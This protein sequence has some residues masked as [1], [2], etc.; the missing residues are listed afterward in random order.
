MTKVAPAATP[1][2]EAQ[3]RRNRPAVV[4]AA[5][6]LLV[7]VYG[8]LSLLNNPRGTLGTDTG[9]KLATL[10]TMD[11]NDTFD[12]DLGYWAEAYDPDGALHPLY[13]TSHVGERWV[14]VTT[15]P[16]VLAARP[17][18]SLGGERAVLALPMLGAAFA[19]LAA[20]ALARR[21][22][23]GDGWFAFWAVGLAT[24]IAIYALDFWEHAPGVAF[25]VWGIVFAVDLVDRRAGWGG[26]LASGALFGAAATMRTEALV[27]AAVTALVVAA[28]LVH[29]AFMT[30]DAPWRRFVG[31][32]T[33]GI[34]GLGGVLV[35][36]QLLERAVVGGSIRAGRAAGTASMGGEG[37]WLRMREAF[38]TA[39]GLNRFEPTTD[40]ILGG[41]IVTVVAFAAWR[42]TSFDGSHRRIGL[43]ALVAAVW[44][45]GMQMAGGLG[46]V[47]G[48]LSASPLAA[49]GIAI[50]WSARR[51]RTPGAIALAAVPLV[52]FFQFTGGANPQWG[53]RYVLVTGT[54]LAVGA[55]VVL[56]VTPGIA[57]IALFAVALMVTVAGLAW[58]SQRSNTV[59]DAIDELSTSDG[60][61][62]VSREGHVL[63][64]VGAAYSSNERWLTAED[65]TEFAAAAR[66]ARDIDAPVM[67]VVTVPDRPNPT[68]IEGWKRT[69]STRF[70][71]LPGFELVT[72]T[73]EPRAA[74]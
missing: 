16:M 51:W 32:G 73:Y 58:L 4:L 41:L 54:V 7:A 12:P 63:R 13:Y 42:L 9:G 11:R 69:D 70:E 49:A 18:Y 29:G 1:V 6:L 3:D 46:F 53:G 62:L 67:R 59:A 40:W 8:A 38:T 31:L 50:G 57:R 66:I 52:W 28:V 37:L 5:M 21:I 72:T 24:P 30:R 47:P 45:Y 26:A 19:A 10:A 60:S 39:V 71:F 65:N 34:A 74:T 56:A 33:A 55:A 20:R 15:L 27:Y 61:V 25:A 36:N 14:N 64:E 68:T 35:I 44:L 48:V 23:G 43:L 2:L 22:A 17:L